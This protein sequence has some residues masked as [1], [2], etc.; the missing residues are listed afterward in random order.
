MR[1]VPRAVFLMKTTLE[2]I[3]SSY[4]NSY[5]GIAGVCGF[6][7]LTDSLLPRE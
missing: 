7:N 4:T 3:D 6:P 1:G 5:S 2:C